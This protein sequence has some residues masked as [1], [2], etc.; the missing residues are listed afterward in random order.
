MAVGWDILYGG[1]TGLI[2]TVCTSFTNFK[3]KKLD[4]EDKQLGRVHEVK[5]VEANTAAMIAET[6]ANIQITETQVQGATDLQDA[7]SYSR[8]LVAA[9]QPTLSTSL[10]TKLFETEGWLSY[11]AQPVGVLICFFFGIVDTI[12]GIIRPGITVYLLAL[13]TWMSWQA[14]QVLES[15]NQTMSVTQATGLVNQIISA[16][17]YLTMTS[18]TWWFGDRTTAKGM[19]KIFGK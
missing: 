15:I 17:L 7:R 6:E 14:W 16:V 10:A 19:N 9:N 4:M 13:S 18:V 5:M 2:G 3:L 1:L 12:K 11:L 8:L